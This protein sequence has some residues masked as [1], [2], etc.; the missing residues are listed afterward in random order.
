MTIS[1]VYLVALFFI[2]PETATYHVI[3]GKKEAAIA[4]LTLL[5]RQNDIEEVVTKASQKPRS[6]T[7][8]QKCSQ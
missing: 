8:W 3:A 6:K 4:N 2:V 7:R 1:G 5:G